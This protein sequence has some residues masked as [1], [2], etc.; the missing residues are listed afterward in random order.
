MAEAVHVV[1][2]GEL[3]MRAASSRF[4]IPRSSLQVRLNKAKEKSEQKSIPKRKRNTISQKSWNEDSGDGLPSFCR[5]IESSCLGK[6]ESVSPYRK[7]DFSGS[8]DDF[9]RVF[10]NVTESSGHQMVK[11]EEESILCV[12]NCS[13]G[14]EEKNGKGKI[15][16]SACGAVNSTTISPKS[17]SSS[18]LLS[19]S[20]STRISDKTCKVA[21]RRKYTPRSTPW[22]QEDLVN[23]ISAV[24]KHRLSIRKA[25]LAFGIPKSSLGNWVNG[26]RRLKEWM[27][28]GM[29]TGGGKSELSETD[30]RS[31]TIDPGNKERKRQ[32]AS[33]KKKTM[34]ILNTEDK[35]GSIKD[36]ICNRSKGFSDDIQVHI[37]DEDAV[38]DGGF[39][40]RENEPLFVAKD[41]Q[42]ENTEGIMI[43]LFF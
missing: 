5:S 11:A 38:L 26:K 39:I 30:K 20:D 25:A 9:L 8:K 1:L 32:R 23:A 16:T 6:D 34:R 42:S 31:G 33:M 29:G 18:A 28:E 40:V 43:L 22:S 27:V 17:V 4:N 35:H 3:S 19:S 15:I 2:S 10:G 41:G 37:I 24:K 21:R 13:G 12:A 14:F 36:L 7:E